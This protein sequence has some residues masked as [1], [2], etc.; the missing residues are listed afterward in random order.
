MVPKQVLEPMAA[1]DTL[2]PA[3]VDA[4]GSVAVAASVAS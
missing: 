3:A 1:V 2:G 4:L